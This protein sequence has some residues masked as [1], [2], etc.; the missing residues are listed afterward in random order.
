MKEHTFWSD[1]L[2]FEVNS[3]SFW[4]LILKVTWKSWWCF[5]QTCVAQK[6]QKQFEQQRNA[7]QKLG[8][9]QFMIPTTTKLTT[10]QPSISSMKTAKHSRN[11]LK[12]QLKKEIAF[13]CWLKIHGYYKAGRRIFCLLCRKSIMWITRI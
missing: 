3:W 1:K 8:I 2:L 13:S 4:I 7:I 9:V 5:Q 10:I 11:I 12:K 6:Q